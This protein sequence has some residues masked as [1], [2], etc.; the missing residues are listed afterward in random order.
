[1]FGRILE[2]LMIPYGERVVARHDNDET[3]LSVS[4]AAVFDSPK[5]FETAVM[6]PAYAEGKWVIV[7]CYDDRETAAK[8]HEKW[9]AVMT[10]EKLPGALVDA[11]THLIAQL[12]R[13]LNNDPLIY[14]RETSPGRNR[15]DEQIGS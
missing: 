4:T 9:L 8:G 11:S 14:E 3:G 7:E 10:A 6:H 2:N 15:I 12:C 13:K 1:M 5:P